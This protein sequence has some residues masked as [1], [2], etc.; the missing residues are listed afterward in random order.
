F[1]G[2]RRV[3]R[4]DDEFYAEVSLPEDVEADGFGLHPAVLDAGLHALGLADGDTFRGLP[5]AWS[6]ITLHATGAAGVRIRLTPVGSG[7]RVAVADGV[8]APVATV[9]SLVLRPVQAHRAGAIADAL[10]DLAWQE[11]GTP[12]VVTDP[13]WA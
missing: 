13:D 11:I 6:G 2:L 9:D 1:Q 10:F 7:V 4:R 12:T 3:W 8:G 5:F